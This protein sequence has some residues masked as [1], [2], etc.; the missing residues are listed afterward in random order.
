[1]SIKI[2]AAVDLNYLMGY[3]ND[4]PWRKPAD[5]KRFKQKTLNQVVVMGRKTYESIGRALPD[6]VNCVISKDPGKIK[7]LSPG[8]ITS[9]SL[10]SFFNQMQFTDKDVWII[11]GS[12][13]YN[14][15]L[16]MDI[17]SEID[18]TI[19]NGRWVPPL[20]DSKEKIKQ[21]SVFFPYIPLEFT[22]ESEEINKEDSSLLHR[23]YVKSYW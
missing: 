17:V 21:S 6:R 19:L 3:N 16:L 20:K 18:L 10:E 9:G 12:E 15:C 11:G 13:I 14:Q 2:I 22:V 7:K 8:V 1:M 23:K 4:I 5:L